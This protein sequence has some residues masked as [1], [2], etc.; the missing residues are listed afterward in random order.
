[1]MNV[2][3]SVCIVLAWMVCKHQATAHIFSFVQLSWLHGIE[4]KGDAAKYLY[5]EG[6]AGMWL[7]TWPTL[8]AVC[9]L[10]INAAVLFGMAW[11]MGRVTR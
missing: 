5:G 10:W 3:A 4:I 9:F 7:L 8:A 1:M 11:R 6:N 2:A